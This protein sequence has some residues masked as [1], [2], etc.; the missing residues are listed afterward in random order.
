[1]SVRYVELP[2]DIIRAFKEHGHTHIRIA[3]NSP[4]LFTWPKP[5]LVLMVAWLDH[6]KGLVKVEV[7]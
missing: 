5:E 3:I 1:M 6:G 7:G 2:D 4:A